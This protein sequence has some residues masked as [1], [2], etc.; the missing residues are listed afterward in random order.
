[1]SNKVHV[2]LLFGRKVRDVNGKVAG[3]IESIH[4]R[5]SDGECRVEEFELGVVA[6]LSVLGISAARLIGIPFVRRPRR[7]PWHQLD[8]SDPARPRL[9]CAVE[10]LP[11]VAGRPVG[12]VGR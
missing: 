7:I 6:L 8:L 4:A 11:S 3:R 5:W 2:E 1:M 12:K 9:R 10:E